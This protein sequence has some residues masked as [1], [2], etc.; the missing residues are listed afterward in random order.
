MRMTPKTKRMVMNESRV[1][2]AKITNAVIQ[3]AVKRIALLPGVPPIQGKSFR[4]SSFPAPLCI[5]CNMCSLGGCGR[6][7]APHLG[8]LVPLSL[9]PIL[10]PQR[11]HLIGGPL[12]SI[13][14]IGVHEL[15][16]LSVSCE[17]SGSAR[18][19]HNGRKTTLST[20]G[21]QNVEEV[22][23]T[24]IIDIAK[25]RYRGEANP[26]VE[27]SCGPP[28]GLSCEDYL[29]ESDAVSFKEDPHVINRLP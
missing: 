2:I 9:N 11:G 29:S 21:I 18:P 25:I 15:L 5:C 20:L 28:F 3:R 14:R 22:V 17:K 6:S 8:Q 24:W 12:T 13:R 1:D 23:T 10:L 7:Q 27:L 19:G 26:F 16:P 4:K